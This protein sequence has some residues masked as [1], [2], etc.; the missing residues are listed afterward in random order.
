MPP[1]D[2]LI[3]GTNAGVDDVNVG[4]VEIGLLVLFCFIGFAL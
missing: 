3:V 4:I 2:C 1:G